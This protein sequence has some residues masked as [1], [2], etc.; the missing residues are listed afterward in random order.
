VSGLIGIAKIGVTHRPDND[1]ADSETI[2]SISYITKEVKKRDHLCLL[3][4]PTTAF[5]ML[6]G[7]AS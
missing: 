6:Q 2:L 7:I 5:T 3:M 1:E 4:Q